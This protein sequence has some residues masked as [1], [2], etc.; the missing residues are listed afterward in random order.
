[1]GGHIDD[2]RGGANGPIRAE[3]YQQ[4]Y[5]DTV[6]SLTQLQ[7]QLRDDPNTARDIQGLMRD[8]R[9]LD[10]NATSN[11]YSND[12]MLAERIQAA[13]AGLEQVEMELR[14]KVDTSGNGG[15]VRSPGNETVPQGYQDAVAQ[16]FRK[17]SGGK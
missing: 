11:A 9:Q 14:R 12:P 16:Y 15:T 10:P 3:D 6:Q 5:R 17:L 7:Q 8:L 13:M 2:P 4:S 1:M